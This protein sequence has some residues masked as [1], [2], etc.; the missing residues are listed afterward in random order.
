VAARFYV[1]EDLS[2]AF[3]AELRRLGHDVLHTRDAGNRRAIDPRQ[4]A[5]AVR[6]DRSLVTANF[7]DFRMLH[8]AWLIW[9]GHWPQP[10]G[11]PGILVVPNENLSRP[12]A[13]AL[14]VDAFVGQIGDNGLRT[15]LFR[16]RDAVGWTD[17]TAVR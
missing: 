9:S 17:F 3:A 4:L 11:H 2:N 10:V 8:E 12:T 14:F 5:F 1:D 13:L 15:R 7:A 16:Y 6:E